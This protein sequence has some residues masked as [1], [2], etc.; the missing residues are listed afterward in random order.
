MNQET[1]DAAC[2]RIAELEAEAERLTTWAERSE[3]LAVDEGSKRAKA[4]A[5]LQD[6]DGRI[7][8]AEAALAELNEALQ[9]LYAFLKLGDVVTVRTEGK[10][11]SVTFSMDRLVS[12]RARAE[13]G[14]EK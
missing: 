6:A 10:R 7:W 5:A 13:E 11:G 9:D 8:R 1:W 14:S 2:A 3:Q 12:L 4:E